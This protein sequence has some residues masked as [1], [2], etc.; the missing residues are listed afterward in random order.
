MDRSGAPSDE[1]DGADGD[2]AEQAFEALRGEVAALRRGVELIYRQGQDARGPA[3]AGPDYSPTLGAIAKELKG[4]GARLDAMERA[5]ALAVT[6]AD[7]AA[8]VRRELH[9]IG[10]DARSGLVHSQAQLD[11]TVRELRGM[12]GSAREWRDQKQW[13][14]TAGACGAMAGAVLWFLLTAMLPWGGGTWLAGLAWGGRWTAGE[15]MM[16]DANPGQWERMVRLYKACPQDST[17][18]LCEAAEA[19]RTIPPS[20][21]LPRENRTKQP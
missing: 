14:W 12:I 1:A 19:V 8:G 11:G 17:T 10:Q 5:P 16:Q 13:L 3:E 20:R 9:Q 21:P 2:G 6:A 4:I 15:A 7:Q 18:D